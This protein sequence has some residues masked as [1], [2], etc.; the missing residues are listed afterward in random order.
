MGNWLGPLLEHWPEDGPAVN[1]SEG[2]QDRSGPDAGAQLE[3]GAIVLT[4]NLYGPILP[5][6]VAASRW[7]AFITAQLR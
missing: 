2:R 7:A 5:S 4:W 3:C 6:P 1:A